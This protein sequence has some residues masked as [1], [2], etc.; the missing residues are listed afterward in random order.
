MD[1]WKNGMAYALGGA[2]VFLAGTLFRELLEEMERE[3]EGVHKDD[4]APEKENNLDGIADI[5][6]HEAEAA[7]A[8]CQTDEE[9][10]AVARKI[11]AAI[12]ELQ[13]IL[14]NKGDAIAEAVIHF[15]QADTHIDWETNIKN[16]A[17]QFSW[18]TMVSR[19]EDLLQ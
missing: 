14:K 10:Q 18:E 7:M 1:D 15:F 3:E 2:A 5:V 13:S 4:D 8:E 6:R 17:Q 19:I 9:R 16:K 11:E 12:T